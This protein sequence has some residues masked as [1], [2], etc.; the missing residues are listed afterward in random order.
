MGLKLCVIWLIKVRNVFIVFFVC[1]VSLLVLDSLCR[2]VFYIEVFLLC[3]CWCS[4]FSVWLLMLCGGV[5]MVCLKVVLL[6]WLVV[7]CR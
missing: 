6:C 4:M 5:F 3:V 2:V 7:R 1:L